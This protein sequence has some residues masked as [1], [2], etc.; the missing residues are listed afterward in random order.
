MLAPGATAGALH[1]P[2]PPPQGAAVPTH[3]T[4]H[5]PPCR[6]SPAPFLF[7]VQLM[8]PC[9]PPISLVASWAAPTAVVG[10]VPA[11]LVAE[12]E[13][14]TGGAAPDSVRAFFAGLAE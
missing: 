9:V 10:K 1:V 6:Q 8:V 4:S 13:Q 11:E 12:Y 7:C 5:P 14:K 3:P 2:P